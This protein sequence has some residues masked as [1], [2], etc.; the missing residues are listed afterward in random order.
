[1]IAGEEVALVKEDAVASRV[2]GRRD[3]REVGCECDLVLAIDDD[4]GVWHRG[5][6]CGVDDARRAEMFGEARGVGDVVAV[7]QKD[8]A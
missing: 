1:M 6:I 4:L 7:R 5:A 3:D 2:S 8:E